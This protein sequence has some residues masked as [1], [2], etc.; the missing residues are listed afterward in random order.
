MQIM[1]NMCMSSLPLSGYVLE[2]I[3][4]HMSDRI[5]EYLEK[6][7][8]EFTEAVVFYLI[9]GGLVILGRRLKVSNNLGHNLI[10]G[11]GGK[12]EPEDV[13]QIEKT[14]IREFIEEIGTFV[15][16]TTGESSC[17]FRP[18]KWE[19]RGKVTFLYPHKPSKDMKV[20]VFV[21]TEWEGEPV[22]TEAIRPE[23]PFRY[24]DIPYHEMWADNRL[25]LPNVLAG[26]IVNIIIM[27]DENGVV[28]E[29]LWE[30]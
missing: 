23:G 2:V 25:W 29:Q 4:I 16:S 10:S 17:V 15:D 22:E 6:Q 26:Q 9:K 18:L 20:E 8:G 21:I 24:E 3:K 12:V 5:T 1:C 11:I 13:G 14:L 19:Y 27:Y 7:E 30:S 28:V